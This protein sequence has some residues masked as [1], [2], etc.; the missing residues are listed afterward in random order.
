M[1]F[2][3]LDKTLLIKIT[4]FLLIEIEMSGFHHFKAFLMASLCPLK[5]SFWSTPPLSKIS[6]SAPANAAIVKRALVR[7]HNLKN[8][9]ECTLARIHIN[10][11][12]AKKKLYCEI[13]PCKTWENI[14][15]NSNFLTILF[16]TRAHD[17]YCS[18]IGQLHKLFW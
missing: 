8:M 10:A 16:S 18:D 11:V 3:N 13:Q 6:G 4:T 17:I 15:W 12:T 2:L 9:R 1:P 14:G 7:N 5:P